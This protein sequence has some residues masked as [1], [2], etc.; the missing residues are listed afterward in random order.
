MQAPLIDKRSYGDIVAQ[1]GQLAGQFSGWQARPDGQ[2]DPGLALIQI[3]GRFAEL[4]IERLNRAPDQNYLAFLNLIGA[5]PLPPRAARVPLTFHLA[6][7]SPVD[8]VVPAGA[9]AAAPAGDAGEVVFETEREL[10]VTRSQLLA[11]YVSDT[12]ADTYSDRT[13]PATGAADQPFAVFAGDQPSPH[14]LY[15]ACDPLL[16]QPGA[17][18]ITLTLVSPDSW[19]WQNWPVSWAYW[20]GAGWQAATSSSVV[21]SG[22]WRVSL[23]ALP[24]LTPT[25]VSGIQAGWLRAQLDLPLPPGQSGQLPESIAIGARSPQ[26]VTLPLSPFPADS[27]VQRFY[28]SADEA[29]GAGGAKVTVHVHLSQPGAGAGVALNWL[30]QAGDQWL[31]LGQSSA[32]AVQTGTSGFVFQD[33]TKAFTQSG[34]ISFHVPM[35]WPRSLYRTRTGRWLRIDIASGQYSTPPV[36]DTLTVDFGWQLPQLG[37]IQAS[38][39]PGPPPAPGPAPAAFCNSAEIDLSKD[40]YPLGTQPQF[41][42]AF[43]VAC[44]EA[45]ASPGVVV[46]LGVTLTNPV[47]PAVTPVLPVYTG[48]SP[49]IAWEVSDGSQWHATPAAY[50]FTLSGQ[51]SFT[52]PSPIAQATVNGVQKYW[53]RARLVSGSYGVPA[54]YEPQTDGSYKFH[55]ATLA[56]PVI[57][58]LT[59][60][61]T[62]APQP[63]VPVTAC[64]AYNDFS[65]ADNS[66]AAGTAQGPLFTPFSPTADTEPALYLGFDQPFSQR[67]VTLFLEVEPPLPEQVVADQLT[68]LTP[69][70]ATQTTWDYCGPDGWQP[71]GA[72]DETGG[73]SDRG[74][75]TFI[76][77]ADLVTRSCFGQTMSWLRLRW[78]AGSFPLPPQLRRVLLNTTWAA[79]V[80]T[81]Q[82]EILGS[83]NGDPGQSFTAAQTPVQP[84]QQVIVREPQ[85]PAPAEEQ[86]L[87]ELEGAG[88]VT[89]TLDA[90]G[91][92]DEIWVRWHAVADFYASGPRDRHYTADPL[93]GVIQFGDGT[94]GL[95]P[96]IGQSNIRMTYQ[97]GGGEQGNQ[98]TATIVELKSSVPYIDGVTNNQP[99][100]GG[101]PS[102]PIARLQGRGPRMLRHRDR[103]VAAADLEDLALAASADVATAAAIVPIFNPY[104]LWLDP[105]A[106]VPTPDHAAVEAG[107]MGVIIV[108]AEPGSVRP[109]PSLVLLRQ[110][111][112]Y[113]RARCS[114]TADLWVAGPEW[115]AVTVQATVVVTS[116]EVA[117]QAGDQARST[118]Q[119][120]LHPLTGGPA[121]QGWPL[122]SRPHASELSALL[123]GLSGVDHVRSLTVSCEPETADPELKLELE[124]ILQRPMTDPSDQPEREQVQQSWLARAL[125]Y[126]QPPAI[127][128]ALS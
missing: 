56:P 65:Y 4:V 18:D 24:A 90:A 77:P 19:Q 108:P 13:G 66:A 30:Y 50:A 83:G 31:A 64:L 62:T 118:V 79:Q 94:H 116:V 127:S 97:A 128:V 15:L 33:G 36:A 6:S 69:A 126:C 57:K 120:Y 103:A 95:L 10:V 81:V 29:F 40:F 114:P 89:V 91:Q 34:D 92:P 100:Q 122:G 3:F 32:S 111:Q 38:G 121:G 61:A 42:D 2:P 75:V 55:P 14:Q 101:A 5:S 67:S 21:Q 82:N 71:L 106:P 85:R 28:L 27:P 125:I 74:L 59:I 25:A 1:T 39:Q 68:E 47:A 46:T 109:T 41:N 105:L 9:L 124:A 113:L 22:A 112:D 99:A 43:Y 48:A 86:A 17:K 107:Q 84:G 76:G 51:V 96:P 58:T 23:P 49:T 102:E 20:D 72:A 119:G 117:D 98:D 7:G 54:Y 8:A 110:V 45:L 104:S 88:A 44:P 78:Q 87:A 73:L 37:S 115:I 11:A 70:D 16:T 93:S 35:S 53:L 52:L 80:T 12:E 26:D 63:P 123:E 60:T